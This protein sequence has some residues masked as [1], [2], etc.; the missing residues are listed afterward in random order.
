MQSR[1]PGGGMLSGTAAY[2]QLDGDRVSEV[3]LEP[4]VADVVRMGARDKGSRAETLNRL[5]NLFVEAREFRK[6]EG[7]WMKGSGPD[8]D[9]HPTSCG[10]CI[11]LWTGSVL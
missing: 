11:R 7:A 5:Q 6:R 8:P 4:A 1:F 10:V 2:I 3:V 9:G